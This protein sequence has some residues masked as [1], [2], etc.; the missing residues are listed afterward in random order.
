MANAKDREVRTKKYGFIGSCQPESGDGNHLTSS[1]FQ[2]DLDAAGYRAVA[3]GEAIT[4]CSAK[5]VVV[6]RNLLCG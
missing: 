2:E 1:E 6:Q 3:I 5:D 4:I